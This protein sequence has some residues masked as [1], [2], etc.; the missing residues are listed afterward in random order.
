MALRGSLGTYEEQVTRKDLH[1]SGPQP[2]P[3]LPFC[4]S[5]LWP[6]CGQPPCTYPGASEQA[7]SSSLRWASWGPESL[8]IKRWLPDLHD[9]G[10]C[11]RWKVGT[12]RQPVPFIYSLP[13]QAKFLNNRDGNCPVW[14]KVCSKVAW[15]KATWTITQLCTEQHVPSHS[16]CGQFSC[17]STWQDGL[18]SSLHQPPLCAFNVH[19]RASFCWEVCEFEFV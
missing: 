15:Q 5:R 1:T 18:L 11:A 12:T 3:R 16:V 9:S 10:P 14:P 2:A 8:D 19:N 13:L 6:S 4:S 17:H 7:S